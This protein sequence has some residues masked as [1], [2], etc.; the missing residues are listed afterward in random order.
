MAYLDS[1]GLKTFWSKIKNWANTRFATGVQNASVD[2]GVKVDILNGADTTATLASTT[3]ANATTTTNGAMSATDKSKL[4]GIAAKAEVNQNAFGKV[5]VGS[6]TVA[7]DAKVDTLTLAG[8][9]VTLTPDATNDKVTIGITKANV[10]AALG[11]TPPTKDTT[12][13]LPT[14][15]ADTLGGVKVGTNLS[16]ADGVL[17][18]ADDKVDV[19]GN[20]VKTIAFT[21]ISYTGIKDN[22]IGEYNTELLVNTMMVARYGELWIGYGLDNI[23]YTKGDSWQFQTKGSDGTYSTTSSINATQYTGN[24]ATATT[25]AS[26]SKVANALTLKLNGTSQ[27]AFDGSAA[28]EIDITASSVGAAAS[29]HTHKYAGSSTAGGSAT[30][31]VKLDSSAGSSTVPVYFSS[32]KPVACSGIATQ[33]Y[34]TN[35][36]NTAQA[37]AARYQG[38]ITPDSY[39]ALA[40]AEKGYY[41][42]VT[43]AGTIAGETCEAGDMV[44]CNTAFSGVASGAQDAAKFDVVQ[45]NITAIPDSEINALS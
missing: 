14:A 40:S 29:S 22:L 44:F 24:A 11:Y 33:T 35:A 36:I 20:L 7:A 38:G 8:S 26:A 15:S 41:W 19:T 6:T 30:S 23:M 45:T 43:T 39:K 28:K 25:A 9:N 31:A 16:I 34:V 27:G 21:G 13:T 1:N 3:I 37:N 42:V 2:G 12:Y 17:S 4:D 10:T 5:V 32:G 18:A